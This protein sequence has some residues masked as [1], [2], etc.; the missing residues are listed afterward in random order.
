MELKYLLEDLPDACVEGNQDIEL[1]QIRCDSRCVEEGDL[2]VAVR[3]GQEQDR[4]R[5]VDHAIARGARAVMVEERIERPGVTQVQVADCRAALAR[6]AAR[7]YAFP[8]RGLLNV[9]VTGTNGKTTT[10][11]L[12]R[13]ALEAAGRPCG[14]L[15]TL[16]F[17]C[18]GELEKMDNTTP[19]AVQLHGF[20]RR[21]VDAGARVAMLEV[22]SHGLALKRVEGIPFQAAVFT[23][24]TRDHLDFHGT[25]EAYFAAKARLFEGLQEGAI[26][27]LNADDAHAA[28]LARRTRACVVTYG[29]GPEAEVR[30][31]RA[32]VGPQG[33]HL[34]LATP[35]GPI[36]VQTHLIGRFNYYNTMAVVA[37]GLA[38]NLDAEGLRRGVAALE[39]VPGRCEPIVEG[40]DFA[41]VVDY[42]HTPDALER[43][44]DAAR[45]LGSGRLICVCGCGGDRDRGK[46]SLMG[47]VAGEQADWTVLTSDNPRSEDPQR[48]MD[49]MVA[50]APDPSA[51]HREV[52][53]AQAIALALAAAHCGDV[54]V[55]AGKG[56]EQEQELADRVVAFDDRVVA[57]RVLQDLR[58]G[59]RPPLCAP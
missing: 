13:S 33:T 14:Y 52:D 34:H 28:E 26:A 32:A 55:I 27:V 18:A 22:S 44:L 59:E 48:I 36:E 31:Q 49:E 9:G 46:R 24:L 10:A 40:Q 35:A 30:L 16:G 51:M 3:G 20:L 1:G 25:W 8:G 5:F 45:D 21:L 19:E 37:T 47:R 6:M 42:A 39:C 29:C 2:F 56:H 38:L 50:G 57:R 53:R 11:F 41:V 4:H 58:A 12:L 43:V 15:G 7:F 54:V 17:W 23:N